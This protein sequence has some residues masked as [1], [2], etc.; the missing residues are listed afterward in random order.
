MA[1]ESS[2]ALGCPSPCNN[3]ASFKLVSASLKVEIEVTVTSSSVSTIIHWHADINIVEAALG[4]IE[5]IRVKVESIQVAKI[6][7]VSVSVD[8][9]QVIVAQVKV[10]VVEIKVQSHAWTIVRLQPFSNHL[11]QK[12]KVNSYGWINCL[13]V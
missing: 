4:Q 8:D 13:T 1:S 5:V 11:H 6:G 12:S 2:N 3:S 10:Q 7:Y 9:V